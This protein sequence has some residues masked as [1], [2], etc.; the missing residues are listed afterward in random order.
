MLSLAAVRRAWEAAHARA[1]V[2]GRAVIGDVLDEEGRRQEE[3]IG[4]KQVVY[5][6]LDVTDFASWQAAVQVAEETFGGLNVLVNNAGTMNRTAEQYGIEDW[7]RSI[8]INLSGQFLGAKAALPSLLKSAL[9]PPRARAR[10]RRPSAPESFILAGVRNRKS[11]NRRPKP[12]TRFWFPTSGFC[13]SCFRL[14][15]L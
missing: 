4:P 6:H 13:P 3:E 5:T 1:I 11:E 10:G 15:I 7:N 12:E 9:P 8:A 2:G 14:L